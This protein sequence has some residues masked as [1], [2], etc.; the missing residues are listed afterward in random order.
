MSLIGWSK[1]YDSVNE[2]HESPRNEV[3]K[4]DDALDGWLA[5]QRKEREKQQGQQNLGEKHSSADEVFV[6]ARSKEEIEEISSLN[7]PHSKGVKRERMAR[8]KNKADHSG[9]GL[10]YHKFT[11]RKQKAMIEANNAGMSK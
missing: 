7:D 6:M 5:K 1:L 11:D 9:R 3:I 4:D 2:A 8:L 10:E